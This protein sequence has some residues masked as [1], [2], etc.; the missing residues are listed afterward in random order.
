MIINDQYHKTGKTNPFFLHKGEQ[1][2]DHF[3]RKA[4]EED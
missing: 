4:W 2:T 1:L 3:V